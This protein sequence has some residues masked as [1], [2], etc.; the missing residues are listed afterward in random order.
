[1]TD[2]EYINNIS[3]KRKLM[4]M[5]KRIETVLSN[6]EATP[7]DYFGLINVFD[8]STLSVQSNGTSVDT[9]EMAVNE[10]MPIHDG[11][12]FL[13]KCTDTNYIIKG[14]NVK[15]VS[16]K[17]LDGIDTFMI[18]VE[19]TNGSNVSICIY[20]TDTNVKKEECEHYYE[21]DVNELYEYLKKAEN[22]RYA[23]AIDDAFGYKTRFNEA[24]VVL[25]EE[26]EDFGY[27]LHIT[28]GTGITVDLPLVAD[29]CNEIFMKDGD[30]N[31]I[32]L[33]RPY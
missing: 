30:T 22:C 31:D 26:D 29:S 27:N 11:Y 6:K 12:E 20:H 16:G 8:Y 13:Q 25:Q 32:F 15:S 19:L 24:T 18:T 9:M 28:N 17:M 5:N 4:I 1:M 7:A 2:E 3:Q 23:I 21:S 33:I 14:G 10:F